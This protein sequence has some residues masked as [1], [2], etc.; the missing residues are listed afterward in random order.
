MY[1]RVSGEVVSSPQARA[2]FARDR[3]APKV[4]TVAMWSRADG[5]T[6]WRNCREDDADHVRN[7]EVRGSH[8]GLNHNAQVLL[9][10]AKVLAEINA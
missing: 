6:N 4:P 7:I 1:E 3:E 2:R 8:L 9:A 5:I 10:I